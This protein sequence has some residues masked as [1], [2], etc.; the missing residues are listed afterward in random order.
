M[1]KINV[2]MK[3]KVDNQETRLVAEFIRKN[4]AR[5]V[6]GISITS[7]LSGNKYMSL[8]KDTI[9]VYLMGT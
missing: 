4:M 3:T 1:A 7:R 2:V 8:D 9:T 6:T 5:A